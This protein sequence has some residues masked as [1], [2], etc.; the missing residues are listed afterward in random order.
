MSVVELV[1]DPNEAVSSLQ[2]IVPS[3]TENVKF[4]V[5]TFVIAAGLPPVMET[6]GAVVSTVHVYVS[7]PTLPA[8]S[9]ERTVTVCE[10]CPRPVYVTD[11]LHGE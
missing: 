7:C 6:V 8:E 2:R 9:V 11:V 5:V 4:A 1:H 10:P 3:D